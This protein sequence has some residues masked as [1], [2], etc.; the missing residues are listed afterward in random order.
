MGEL[1][2]IKLLK[3]N[4]VTRSLPLTFRGETAVVTGASGGIGTAIAEVLMRAGLTVVCLSRTLPD[5]VDGFAKVQRR[6]S[7]DVTDA[8]GLQPAL[9]DAVGDGTVDY[10]VN[11][12]GIL[13]NHGFSDVPLAVWR[14]SLEVNL[15]GAYNVMNVLL[16]RLAASG[17]GAVVNV[18]SV[19]SDRVVA[20]SNPDPNPHYAATKAGLAMLTRTAARAGAGAGIRVNSVSPGFVATPMAAGHGRFDPLPPALSGRV[21]LGRFAQPDEIAA[22]VAFLLSDQASYVTGADLRIDGGFSLT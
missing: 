2:S 13:Q 1:L 3:G 9:A 10:V 14:R 12:A 20:L 19:E 11:S 8:P 6:V 22:C 21:A 16:P 18:T 15:I 4:D 17:S 7:A 5:A